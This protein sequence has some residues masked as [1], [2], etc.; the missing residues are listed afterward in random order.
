MTL[1]VLLAA[2][3]TL[4]SSG[5]CEAEVTEIDD[6]T[7]VEDLGFAAEDILVD[8][9]GTRAVAGLGADGAALDA[10]LVVARGEGR[11]SFVDYTLVAKQQVKWGLG[12]DHDIAVPS[13][14]D[15]LEIPVDVSFSTADGTFDLAGE[16]TAT[17][18]PSTTN[19]HRGSSIWHDIDPGDET[20]PE[21]EP[22][23]DPALFAL[24]TDDR[25]DR[26]EVSWGENRETTVF[27]TE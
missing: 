12:R 26:L 9:V 13:C 10:T 2:G 22:G 5:T 1:L 19:A 24:F 14:F 8:L 23:T 16:G 27:R 4:D 15:Q 3:C 21:A 6:D 18:D 17:N 20:L 25:L 11:A 7:L